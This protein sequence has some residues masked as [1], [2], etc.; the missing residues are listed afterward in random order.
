MGYF[1]SEWLFIQKVAVSLSR[2]LI[3]TTSCQKAD[4][5]GQSLVSKLYPYGV[6]K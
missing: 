2:R 6:L 4:R 3:Q 1:E 5:K